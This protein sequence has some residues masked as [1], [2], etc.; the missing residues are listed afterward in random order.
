MHSKSR[1]MIRLPGDEYIFRILAHVYDPG[2]KSWAEKKDG[3][4]VRVVTRL[5]REGSQR[6]G[7]PGD[8]R[9]RVTDNVQV[10][11][12]KPLT[13]IDRTIWYSALKLG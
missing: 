3:T 8:I 11:R 7:K 1:K 12:L 4:K 9:V 5:Q 10:A 13:P 2:R 6:E